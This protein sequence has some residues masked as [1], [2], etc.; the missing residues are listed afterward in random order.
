MCI[1]D[2]LRLFFWLG[3][4]H[5][6]KFRRR[7]DFASRKRLSRRMRSQPSVIDREALLQSAQKYTDK[8]KY[9]RAI[10]EYQ[11]IIQVDPGDARTLLKMGDL[12]VKM[13]AYAEAIATYDRVGRQYAQQGFHVKAVWVYKQIREIL[14]KH[15]PQLE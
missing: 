8:K 5:P 9:D 1:R 15:V 3:T 13:G 11:K 4:S 10:L 12:Q 6:R 2:R 7:F 14:H